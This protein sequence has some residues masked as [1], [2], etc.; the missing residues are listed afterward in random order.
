M[1]YNT[2]YLEGNVSNDPVYGT[3]QTGKHTLR[4]DLASDRFSRTGKVS[5]TD[6]FKITLWDRTA[7]NYKDVITKGCPVFVIGSV[8]IDKK[9]YEGKWYTNVGVSATKC[10]LTGKGRQFVSEAEEEA[11]TDVSGQVEIP[12]EFDEDGLPF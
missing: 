12:P 10:I 9:Q 7:D 11:P 4:F 5:G 3:T 1:A 8:R 2:I 6:F